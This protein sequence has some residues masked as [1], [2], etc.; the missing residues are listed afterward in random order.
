MPSQ[1]H[2]WLIQLF[3]NRPTLAPLLLNEAGA[4]V[5][6]FSEARLDS[7]DLTDTTPTEYRADAVVTLVKDD[8]VMSV[9]VEVQRGRDPNKRWSWPVYQTTLR[10][11]KRSPVA[12]LTVCPD[13]ATADWCRTPIPMG[14]PGFVFTPLV[15]S[16][17]NMPV[18]TQAEADEAPELAALSAMAHSSDQRVVEVFFNSLRK[19]P[20]ELQQNYTD[21]VHA[22]LPEAA[23]KYLEEL[24]ATGT[25][26][27]QSDFAKKYY[28]AGHSDGEALGEAKSIV[29]VLTERGIEVPEPA[30]ARIMDCKDTYLLGLWLR[31]AVIAGS[32][33][34]L[35]LDLE[36]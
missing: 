33:D 22:A 13:D 27:Y 26:T 34:D 35:D 3:H 29:A 10:A 36:S 12:L 4:L 23:R 32:L 7:A 8:E 18:L 2:E 24:M 25:Y 28:G 20:P 9:V 15:V 11:R 31:Q 19:I 16:P 30:R 14:H 21:F 17:R 6:E 5:P 1:E